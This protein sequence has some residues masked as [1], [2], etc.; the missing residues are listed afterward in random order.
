MTTA[1]KRLPG[2]SRP[3][4]PRDAGTEVDVQK[5]RRD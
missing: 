4:D 3:A 5:V 1:A 2:E